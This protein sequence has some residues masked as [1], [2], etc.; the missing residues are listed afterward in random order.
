MSKLVL[1][2]FIRQSE[3]VKTETQKILQ[4]MLLDI[5]VLQLE[6]AN[7]IPKPS[8]KTTGSGQTHQS[9]VISILKMLSEVL[10]ISSSR[11]Q[12]DGFL[13]PGSPKVI[14][15][16]SLLTQLITAEQ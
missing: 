4:E 7:K 6:K 5:V 14:S 3:T 8:S 10:R 2:L 12:E 13:Q 16:I 9:S 15:C 11:T 1:R